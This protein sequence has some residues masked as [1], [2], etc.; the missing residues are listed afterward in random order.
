MSIYI[1]WAVTGETPPPHMVAVNLYGITVGA[2]HFILF[3]S[4]SFSFAVQL[5]DYFVISVSTHVNKAVYASIAVGLEA[6]F[7][8]ACRIMPGHKIPLSRLPP[9]IFPLFPKDLRVRKAHA[10]YIY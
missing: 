3:H 9:Q 1:E 10:L 5:D 8:V 4:Y 2:V 6:V 7:V